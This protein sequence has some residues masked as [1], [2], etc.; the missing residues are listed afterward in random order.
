MGNSPA[1]I[2]RHY[3]SIVSPAD[4]K[5]YFSITPRNLDRLTKKIRGD[6]MKAATEKERA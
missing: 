3:R 4:A 6:T 1:V 2:F 5:R